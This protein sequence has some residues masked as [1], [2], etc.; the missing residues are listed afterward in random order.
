[1]MR[2]IA[3]LMV[4]VLILGSVQSLPVWAGV[5]ESGVFWLLGHV[6]GAVIGGIAGFFAG[7]IL[8]AAAGAG[9]MAVINPSQGCASC[10]DIG[11]PIVY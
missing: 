11:S 4:S 10:R 5:D 8:G 9:F 7:G 6:A 2:I 1:M 3:V